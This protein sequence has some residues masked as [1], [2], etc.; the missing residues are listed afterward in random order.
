MPL[1][2]WL[3]W[4]AGHEIAAQV[5]SR[6]Y[7]SVSPIQTTA[8]PA[9]NLSVTVLSINAEVDRSQGITTI[10][11]K[12]TDSKLNIKYQF[13]VMQAAAV[14]TALAKKLKMPADTVRKLISYQIKEGRA[15]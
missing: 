4:L 8:Q 10:L 7:D 11:V 9:K 3:I 5:L 2:A 12:T 15:W 6:S 1:I 13:A 14:E